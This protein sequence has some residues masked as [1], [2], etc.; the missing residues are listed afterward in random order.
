[1]LRAVGSEQMDAMK[2]DV[3]GTGAVCP[4]TG[5]K[6]DVAVTPG[7]EAEKKPAK[8][9]MFTTADVERFLAVMRPLGTTIDWMRQFLAR[10]HPE[11]GRS[12]P[13]CPFVPGALDQ[14]T[15]WLTAVNVRSKNEIVEVVGQYRDHFLELE[16]KS[17]DL[18]LD[19][20]ILI[21]FPNL[22]HDDA[23]MVDEAQAELK[24]RFVDAGLM[25]GEFH[26]RNESP[27]LRNEDFRPLRSPVPML[28]IRHMVESDLPFLQRSLDP[29]AMRIAF[30]RSYLRRLGASL[31]RRN[32]DIALEALVTAELDTRRLLEGDCEDALP[33]PAEC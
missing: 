19:K 11:L 3:E 26:E 28:A 14:N 8:P 18:A 17:G 2:N 4:F 7:S 5:R 10:P 33:A 1:M 31:S 9:A 22:T 16:P 15:I 29:P 32:F 30:L 12:G 24:P 27:G 25:I 23:P 6:A 20:A 13:V 21:V